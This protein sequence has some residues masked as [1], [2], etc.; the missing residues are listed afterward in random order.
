V[1]DKVTLASVLGGGA[2]SAAEGMGPSIWAASDGKAGN[3]A[4]V[5]ALARALGET[6]RWIKI[7]HIHGEARRG[8]PIR[9]HPKGWQTVLPAHLWPNP[10]GALPEAERRLFTPPWPTLWIGAGRR[11]A[12]Y[13]AAMRQWSEGQTFCVHILDPKVAPSRFD[14]LVTPEHDGLTGENVVTTL[15]SPS[16]F[17]PDDIEE[18]ELHFA[19]LH[20]E[21]EKTCVVI[22]GGNS[23]THTMSPNRVEEIL[24]DL[25]VLALG[26][27]RLRITCSRRTPDEAEAKVRAFATEMGQRFWSGPADG[28]NPYL[29]W[30]LFSKTALVTE[31]S[32]NM[33]SDAAYFG[34]PIHLLRLE[35]RSEK[36]DRLHHGFVDRG[37]ARW[38]E[39]SLDRWDYGPVREVDRVAD[40]LVERLVKRWPQPYYDTSFGT[41]GRE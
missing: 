30:L 11:T 20:D 8:E 24:A 31:D 29:A 16:Y 23:A 7:A 18:A 1:S 10:K 35:G 4:Q 34:L 19:D 5:M 36:F 9:L 32:A 21:G 6:G 26:G 27:W 28:R 37:A 2:P 14:M 41:A 12:P 39:G 17:S 33:L 3:E 25:K 15:G 13:S 22:L 38:F 40:A